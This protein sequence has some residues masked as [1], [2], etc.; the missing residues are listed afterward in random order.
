MFVADLC[1]ARDGWDHT[2]LSQGHNIDGVTH[3][4]KVSNIVRTT[5]A[6]DNF[7]TVPSASLHLRVLFQNYAR[8]VEIMIT[9]HRVHKF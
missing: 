4:F 3:V 1:V 2:R 9:G 5:A 7:N 6:T 8:N